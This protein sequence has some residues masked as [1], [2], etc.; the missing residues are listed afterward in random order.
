MWYNACTVSMALGSSLSAARPH[1]HSAVTRVRHLNSFVTTVAL[2]SLGATAGAHV[3]GV[4][5]VAVDAGP[6][7][8][9]CAGETVTL[10][11]R[12]SGDAGPFV[13]SWDQGLGEGQAHDV[14]ADE[15]RAYVVT[16]TDAAGATATDTVTVVV[17]E[18]A[19]VFDILPADV[20]YACGDGL[21]PPV[22]LTV[23][24]A[25]DPAP[26]LMMREELCG[27]A[28]GLAY[29]DDESGVRYVPEVNEDPGLRYDAPVDR[30]R[31]TAMC[32]VDPARE[33]RW[34]LRNPNAFPVY[35][36]YETRGGR[37]AGALVVPASVDLFFFTGLEGNPLIVTWRDEAGDDQQD[38]KSGSLD[39]CGTREYLSCGCPTLRIWDA[40]DR[41][42]NARSFVRRLFPV[43]TG[44]PRFPAGF[45]D[46]VRV[47][48]DAVPPATAPAIA[49]ACDPDVAVTLDERRVD[50]ACPQE[51][52][53]QRRWRATDACGNADS[54]LRVISVSDEVPPVFDGVPADVTVP[55]GTEL[56]TAGPSAADAYSPP[57]QVTA[58]PDSSAV[59]P[60]SGA[61][62]VFR[63]WLA[64]DACG[65]GARARQRI[66]FAAERPTLRVLTGFSPNGDGRNDAFTIENVGA[67]PGTAVR[68]YNRWGL[69]VFAADDYDNSW[70]GTYE[71][72]DLPDGTY[73][74]VLDPAEGAPP[75]A[76]F[77]Q[78]YR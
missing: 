15:T 51:Y 25:F 49:D 24:D 41:C 9:A 8:G 1:T 7:R 66:R 74:Y 37:D 76:G 12:A 36:T 6:D 19:P 29:Y 35:A 40:T 55:A 17:D 53:L 64:V 5:A 38:R 30:L 44:A 34:R 42:G 69:R 43:D 63:S 4:I 59:D 62:E 22:E 32:S 14:V 61:T 52:L 20:A 78:L 48:P 28:A 47:A 13:Y 60:V 39:T 54:V 72:K 45:G 50:G 71:A 18:R 26:T 57:T 2:C 27:E 73:Y 23:S 65:N 77:V 11:A 21:P 31:L 16:A 58:L 10:S 33:R 56:P 46:T 75:Q 70:R 68:I 3:G 67:Y